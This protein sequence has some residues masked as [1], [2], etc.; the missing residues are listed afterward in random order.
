MGESTIECMGCPLT[1]KTQTKPVGSM[2]CVCALPYCFWFSLAVQRNAASGVPRHQH[3]SKEPCE[4]P[5]SQSVRSVGHIPIV[6][7]S[8][9]LPSYF[10]VP[11]FCY[12][13]C[14]PLALFDSPCLSF[15][16][17]TTFSSYP[18]TNHPTPFSHSLTLSI[19]HPITHQG[20]F[21][22]SSAEHPIHPPTCPPTRSPTHP[23]SP[24][25]HH[26][27]STV[28]SLY[29]IND[30]SRLFHMD[31]KTAVYRKEVPDTSESVSWS[32]V[33]QH[34][35]G[36]IVPCFVPLSVSLKECQ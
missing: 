9:N 17:S 4:P 15:P 7:Q 1:N 26:C 31:Y 14:L 2:S 12:D 27:R 11:K 33:F 25:P 32:H 34:G 35:I 21:N 23:T 13:L 3:A 30:H 19:T 6:S 28:V 16:Y 24:P 29:D 8:I 36:M 5:F 20:S 18:S 22:S 10:T